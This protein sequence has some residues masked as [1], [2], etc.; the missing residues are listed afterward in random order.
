MKRTAIARHSR[1]CRSWRHADR[2]GASLWLRPLGGDR[3]Q[4]A[5]RGRTASA[6][7]RSPPRSAL[8]GRTASRSATP[9]R[10]ASTKKIDDSLQTSAHRRHR[11]LSGALARSQRADRGDRGGDGGIATCRQDPGRS[12]SAISVR[13]RSKPFGKVAPVQTVQSPYNLFERA[14]EEDVLPYCRDKNIVTLAYGSL[15]RGLLSGRMTA[16]T[17]FDRGRPAKDRPQI[18]ARLGLSNTCGP[19]K[20]SIGSRRPTTEGASSIL[21][22]AGF[23]TGRTRRSRFGARAGRTN[24]PR[25]RASSGWHIDASAMAE[26]DR[27]LSETIV[28][29]VGPEFMAPPVQL[30][31]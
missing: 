20:G 4:G 15:C 8:T 5:G 11:P 9:A 14:I 17:K 21:H 28:D 6:R 31:A 26:I 7:R 22:C 3:G 12:V 18:P 16:Q 13:R 27:I 23:S 29:A 19:S 10:H 30:A 25:S 24:L 2:Y 1:G